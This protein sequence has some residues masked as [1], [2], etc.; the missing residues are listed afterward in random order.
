MLGSGGHILF[1]APDETTLQFQLCG[2]VFEE[3]VFQPVLLALVVSFQHFQPSNLHVQVHLLFNFGI[4][5][6]QRLDFRIGK[7]LLIHIVA[8]AH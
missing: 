7:R 8:G 1:K 5:R 6:T 2:E 3:P 4:A